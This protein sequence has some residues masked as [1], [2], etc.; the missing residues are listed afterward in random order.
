MPQ[1]HLFSFLLCLLFCSPTLWGQTHFSRSI[2][3]PYYDALLSPPLDDGSLFVV[4]EELQGTTTTELVVLHI[5]SLGQALAS[6]QLGTQQPPTKHLKAQAITQLADGQTVLAGRA[7]TGQVMSAWVGI[8]NGNG[9]GTNAHEVLFQKGA[10]WMDMAAMADSGL[11]VSGQGF[12]PNAQSATLVARYDKNLKLTWVKALSIPNQYLYLRYI[13]PLPGDNLALAGVL[14]KGGGVVEHALAR[15]DGAGNIQWA[16]S[17]PAPVATTLTVEAIRYDGQD[18]LYLS[19]SLY[20]H[21]WQYQM[22][23]FAIDTAGNHVWGR[24]TEASYSAEH[25]N[26]VAD[27]SGNWILH[28]LSNEIFYWDGMSVA[29]SPSGNLL[30]ARKTDNIVPGNEVVADM[31][32]YP[33]GGYVWLIDE[34]S[35]KRIIRTDGQGLMSL[36]CGPVPMGLAVSSLNLIGAPITITSVSGANN[37]SFELSSTR[38][39]DSNWSN[40]TPIGSEAARPAIA[41]TILPQPLRSAARILLSEGSLA[42]DAQLHITDLSGRHLALPVTRLPDG[43]EIQRGGLPA[44]IYAFQILQGGQRIASGKL[45]VAD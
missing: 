30:W 23:L 5:D 34:F 40:C 16:K 8:L 22:F 44:G 41:A 26:M 13:T 43:W 4:G 7:I 19:G 20:R 29:F 45:W 42:D 21:N 14:N 1:K 33:D 18:K 37:G 25:R 11:V 9:Q 27:Q 12:L 31:V 6:W 3:L 39:A 36:P 2:G 17:Y 10:E 15:M 28:G 35:T 24:N 32:R 38:I